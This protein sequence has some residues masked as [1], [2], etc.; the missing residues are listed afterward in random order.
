MIKK[1]LGVLLICTPLILILGISIAILGLEY[2]VYAF[3]FAI[4]VTA[5]ITLCVAKGIDILDGE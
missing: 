2:G 4:L 1:A 5:I 3:V